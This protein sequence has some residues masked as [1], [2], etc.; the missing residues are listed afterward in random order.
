[1]KS[2][3]WLVVTSLVSCS[4][5]GGAQEPPPAKTAA[6]AVLAPAVQAAPA[7]SAAAQ[8]FQR[9]YDSEATGKLDVALDA[10]D[11]LPMPEKEGYVAE[12]R[13]GWL[14]YLLGKNA[15]SIAAYARATAKEP[16]SIEPRIGALAPLGVLR[17]WSEIEVT[18][19][20]VLKRDAVNYSALL[21]L[22]FALYSTARYAD[23]EAGYRGLSVLYPSDVEVKDG[24]GWTL[25][26]LGRGADAEAV[27]LEVLGVAPKNALAIEGLRAARAIKK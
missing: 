15:D 23:A 14:L 5:S 16:A 25:V 8:A 2:V 10:L 6:V 22:S 19:R 11:A 17:K 4:A 18:A 13:R 26:K 21:R 1:M 27:F 20:E 12:L 24:L 7:P 3:H 9:S